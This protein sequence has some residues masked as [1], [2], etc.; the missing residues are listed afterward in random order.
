MIVPTYII[1]IDE[2]I[3]PMHVWKNID[4]VT[5]CAQVDRNNLQVGVDID[6]PTSR[7]ND[8]MIMTNH[9]LH[10]LER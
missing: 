3:S 6:R 2:K 1:I 10:L 8:K 9:T 7:S 5:Y 4:Q